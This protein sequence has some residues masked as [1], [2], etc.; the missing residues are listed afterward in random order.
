MSA[1]W[2]LRMLF[3]LLLLLTGGAKL[4]D[5]NGFVAVVAS[6]RVLPEALLSLSAWSLTVC[7][8]L[9]ALWLFSGRRLRQA[10]IFLLALHLIYLI[11]ILLALGRGLNLPNCGCF[12]VYF[13]RP[14]S[15]TTP[16]EDAVLIVLA[17]WFWRLSGKSADQGSTKAVARR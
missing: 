12:G 10:S 3:S 7:E 1:L 9:L 16:I 13:A 2:L 14:L 4:L 15:W 8:L 11:W 5:M 6:Y 17:V